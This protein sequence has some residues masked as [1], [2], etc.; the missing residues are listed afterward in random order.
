MNR[1]EPNMN[2]EKFIA[3]LES[4][5]FLNCNFWIT[6]TEKSFQYCEFF[7]V[8]SGYWVHGNL[9]K[10]WSRFLHFCILVNFLK[11]LYQRSLPTL[12][13]FQ[14]THLMRIVSV[15]LKIS[16]RSWRFLIGI[17]WNWL[18]S[19]RFCRFGSTDIDLI[20]ND[21]KHKIK[22]DSLP[23]DSNLTKSW[24]SSHRIRSWRFQ[25]V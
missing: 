24:S 17:S 19:F 12:I 2:F 3:R 5:D 23:F 20:I 14:W 7:L 13:S 9:L 11:F 21:L 10:F 15:F 18:I 16:S 4:V 8:I 6:I 25:K 1:T 22:S